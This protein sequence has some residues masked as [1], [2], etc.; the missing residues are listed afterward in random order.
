MTR[1]T[2]RLAPI[3][4]AL[5]LSLHALAPAPARMA[6][7]SQPSLRASPTL[8]GSLS[9]QLRLAP[10]GRIIRATLLPSA[11]AVARRT[12]VAT[13]VRGVLPATPFNALSTTE[14][15]YVQSIT[16]VPR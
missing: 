10:D 14:V 13:G 4:A 8:G 16:F 9:G 5:T 3:A 11:V 12:T 6:A 15:S 1:S 7:G 2:S